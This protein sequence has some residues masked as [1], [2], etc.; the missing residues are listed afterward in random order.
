[1][2]KAAPI[3]SGA[4]TVLSAVVSVEDTLQDVVTAMDV[5]GLEV[6]EAVTV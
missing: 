1:M 2:L 5:V 6:G 4:R 3:D